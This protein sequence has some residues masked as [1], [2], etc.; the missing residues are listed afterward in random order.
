MKKPDKIVVEC[1][2]CNKK[3]KVE[4]KSKSATY[5]RCLVCIGPHLYKRDFENQLRSFKARE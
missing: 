4:E 2:D 5:K 1:K 3:I